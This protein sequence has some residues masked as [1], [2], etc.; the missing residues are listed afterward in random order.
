MPWTVDNA[1]SGVGMVIQTAS[2][3]DHATYGTAN[4]FPHN[5][6]YE[7]VA[8]ITPALPG[9][10]FVLNTCASERIY[11]Q[12]QAGIE[13]DVIGNQLWKYDAE[14]H[15]TDISSALTWTGQ[16]FGSN[17]GMPASYDPNQYHTFG[18]RVTSDGTN[19]T[20]C[21][22]IDNNFID[23]KPLPGELPA[24][25]AVQRN[26]LVLQNARDWWNYQ[27]HGCTQDKCG[28]LKECPRM[29]LR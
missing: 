11:D 25:K 23:C 12:N 14:V 1:Y 15:N 13:W 27:T 3:D 4:S 8:R 5:S 22:Y 9:A 29:E 20:G 16:A 17:P 2:W 24:S 26:F 28:T 6:Y 21:S 10:Y 7:L 19:M 18:M